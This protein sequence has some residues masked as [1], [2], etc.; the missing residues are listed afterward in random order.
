MLDAIRTDRGVIRKVLRG[1]SDAFRLLV[2]RYGGMVYGIACARVGNAVDAEDISQETFVR[3]YQ[4]L[5]RLSSERSVGAWLVKVARH[6]A[7]DW[8]RKQGREMP[9]LAEGIAEA[10]SLPNPAR[11]EL[12]RAIW[13][14]LAT[15]DSE[16]R[17]ILV[18]YY[19]QSKRRREI[20]RLL[21]ISS[22]AAAKRLQRARDELGRRLIDALGDDWASQKR[23]ASR[24]N[25]VMAAI[26]ASPVVWKPSV[27]LAL[28][29]A[30][31]VGASATKTVTGIALSGIL[32]AALLYGGWRYM[33]RPFATK[34][35]TAA[36]TFK[37]EPAMPKPNARAGAESSTS[38]AAGAKQEEKSA[39]AAEKRVA[40]VASTGLRV[41]GLLVD[42]NRQPVAGATVAIDN[43]P[44]A[45]QRR[46]RIL[47]G[48]DTPELDE[49]RR[50][51]VSNQQG[52][53]EFE[54]IPFEFKWNFYKFRLWSRQGGLG[55]CE[56]LDRNPSSNERYYELVMMPEAALAGMVTDM[57]GVPITLAYVGLR[58][59]SGRKDLRALPVNR[60]DTD[61]DGRFT[62]EFFPPGSYRFEVDAIGFVPLETPWVAAGNTD[63]LF[64]LDT[65]NTISGRV[66]EAATGKAL[67]HVGVFAR[68][69]SE[70]NYRL[71]HADADDRGEF[72]IS[73]LIP[74]T[75]LL[76]INRT[77]DDPNVPYALPE[78]V[79]VTVQQGQPVTGVELRAVMGGSVSG[80]V[81][82]ADTGQPPQTSAFVLARGSGPMPWQGGAKIE[83]DG[84]YTIYGFPPGE[85]T[86]TPGYSEL[87]YAETKQ[88]V[89]IRGSTPITGMNLTLAKLDKNTGK[90]Q[91][92]TGKVIDE[93]GAAVEG[94]N[95][96]AVPSDN[97]G[98]DGSS[99]LTDA[100]GEFAISFVRTPKK[101]Y[102]QAFMQGAM[103][104]RAGPI[105]PLGNSCTLRLEP[106]GRIEG[107]VVDESGEPVSGAVVA[108]IGDEDAGSIMNNEA[109]WRAMREIRGTKAG[110][111]STGTFLMPS[112][113][114]GS[115]RLEVYVPA[116]APDVPVAKAHA[117]V[118]AGDTLRTR[119]VIDT[120]GLGTIEGTITMN[121]SP[122]QDTRVSAT[123]YA[124]GL[125]GA[126]PWM[127]SVQDYSDSS[128][129]YVL[130]HIQPGK[131]RVV[132]EVVPSGQTNAD[133]AQH[134]QFVDVE[135]GQTATADFNLST[136][137]TGT[138]EGYVYL[139]GAPE[140]YANVKFQAAN[141]EETAG[142]TNARTNGEGWFHI[143]GLTEGTYAAEASQYVPYS[144]SQL[145]LNEVQEIS[146]KAGETERIDFHLNS[147]RIEGTVSGIQK[148]QQ[149][150]VSLLDGS[151]GIFSLTPQVLQSM[152]ERVLVVM[153]VPQDGPFTFE[154]IPEGNYVLGAVSVPEDASQQEIAPALAAI[155]AGKYTAV[156]VQVVAGETVSVDLA[157]P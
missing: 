140:D 63:L 82:D 32:I 39:D 57:Q 92:L 8:L 49:F 123:S 30:A 61:K 5:D 65:G 128:G 85:Y 130:P 116:A 56:N 134:S 20:A 110:T 129:H 151:G 138:V 142:E 136:E 35:I 79:P 19:F 60:T 54:S 59:A 118:R 94:A 112:V 126:A 14:Q 77:K 28:S 58:G 84:S 111:S 6:V 37:F 102:V 4:W 96:A 143:E 107:T 144:V 11:D 141:A 95:V 50:E 154:W 91:L 115:Y 93:T 31:I 62:F 75:F 41:Y 157:L 67:P 53:F 156:E 147:G 117:Q 42:E 29:G 81:V 90:D 15:L 36:S 68:E 108:A 38:E 69:R 135:A 78:P 133:L 150:F 100:E 70:N 16:Q 139:N 10:P 71:A 7:I 17:E 155:T 132:A 26:A 43:Y 137:K 124:T 122:V 73:G 2:D 24:A 104:R 18:L 44:E 45:N 86:L 89:T 40:A 34:E 127:D 148:G 131:A 52:R 149:A 125:L 13:D 66:V 106:A 97:S 48:S 121:G 88:P 119:L 101:V 76:S 55:A 145:R 113:M 146:V 27:S 98:F 80:R 74:A 12:H 64:Q 51:T 114:A 153:T 87:P 3:L 22:E 23:N 72:T 21:G 152:E 33:S 1:N 120:Q 103:S 9:R 109:S 105:A 25:R 46:L 47:G 99:A 83:K